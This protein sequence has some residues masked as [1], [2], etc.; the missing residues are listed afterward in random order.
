MKTK[1]VL[2]KLV[3]SLAA[4]VLLAAPSLSVAN[5]IVTQVEVIVGGAVYCNTTLACANP[6][7]NL[8]AGGVNLGTGETL[9][10]TQEATPTNH[11]GEDFDTSDRGGGPALIGCSNVGATPCTVQIFIN[12]GSGLVQ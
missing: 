5:L 7:W 2:L 11:G 8:G 4:L 12:S 9:I 1:H 10:L 3:G 6:I